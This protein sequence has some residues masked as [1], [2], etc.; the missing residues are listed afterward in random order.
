[1]T[2]YIYEELIDTPFTDYIHPDYIQELVLRYNQR[3]M[4][5]PVPSIYE[6][7][8]LTNSGNILD[9]EINATIFTYQGKPADFVI[10]RDITERKQ[11]KNRIRKVKLEEERYHELLSHF[12]NNDL[13]KIVCQLEFLLLSYKSSQML[14]EESIDR[15][16]TI[17]HNSSKTIEIVN[18]IFGVLKSPFDQQEQKKR[19]NLLKIIALALHEVQ[20][21]EVTIHRETLDVVILA[22]DYLKAVFHHIFLFCLSSNHKNWSIVIEGSHN[23]SYFCISVRDLYSKPIPKEVIFSISE[24][25]TDEWKSQGYYLN[26][27]LASIIIQY[28]GGFLKIRPFEHKGNEF[29]ICFPLK[30]IQF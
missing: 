26:I 19:Y 30:L 28:Y 23:P 24:M 13:Q 7:R 12:L 3:M 20:P 18:K 6:I 2:G 16:I 4:G 14:D 27:S 21:R 9:V 11:R 17:T 8:L 15:I 1:M 10:V 29:Q 22:D 25:S 5:K